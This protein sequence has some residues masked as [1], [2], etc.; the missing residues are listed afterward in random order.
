MELE[1]KQFNGWVTK[2]ALSAGLNLVSMREVGN[3]MV[4]YQSP[5][6]L[7]VYLHGEGREWH[8]DLPSAVKRAEEMKLK[9]IASLKKQIK[10]LEELKF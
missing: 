3:G 7:T 1:S 2:Y 4:K 5:Y 8:R 9:K 10:K 6:G